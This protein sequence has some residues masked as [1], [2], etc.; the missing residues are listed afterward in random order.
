MKTHFFNPDTVYASVQ[1][2]EAMMVQ[3][4]V[5]TLCN[6]RANA[7]QAGRRRTWQMQQCCSFHFEKVGPI[8]TRCTQWRAY[9]LPV[10]WSSC[11]ESYCQRFIERSHSVWRAHFWTAFRVFQSYLC[12]IYH[13]MRKHVRHS[14]FA[15]QVTN[16]LNCWGRKLWFQRPHVAIGHT[17]TECKVVM[18]WANSPVASFIY[19]TCSVAS[20]CFT[21]FC[22]QKQLISSSR[23]SGG[24]QYSLDTKQ[25]IAA[26]L[27]TAHNSL[28]AIKNQLADAMWILICL[29][30][31]HLHAA[32]CPPQPR[33]PKFLLTLSTLIA[34]FAEMICCCWAVKRG[35]FWEACFWSLKSST[36][37]GSLFLR[38]LDCSP[39][40]DG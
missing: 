6:T 32:D 34:G 15:T 23:R 37:W 21:N 17:H 38:S 16:S 14:S 12:K 33:P 27:E 28:L 25:Q 35:V 36:A 40:C 8:Q 31:I 1:I 4:S 20:T 19:W 9:G 18:S 26:D 7:G 29:S 39:L 3:H 11:Q 22:R 10:W 13:Q 30:K 2:I 24:Q 5:F